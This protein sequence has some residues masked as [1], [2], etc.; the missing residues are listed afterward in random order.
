MLHC[1]TVVLSGNDRKFI[2]KNSKVSDIPG[3]E[4]VRA[5]EWL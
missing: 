2:D 4:C 5:E 3:A 1:V